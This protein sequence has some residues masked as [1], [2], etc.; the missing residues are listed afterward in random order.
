MG[1][2]VPQHE[3]PGLRRCVPCSLRACP[4]MCQVYGPTTNKAAPGHLE[5]VWGSES[6]RI[7]ALRTSCGQYGSV[8]AVACR[9]SGAGTFLFCSGGSAT[10]GKEDIMNWARRLR[11]QV[12]V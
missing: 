2:Y 6:D 5:Q 3:R 9:A 4:V 11:W 7:G 12:A 8:R 10:P 1:R